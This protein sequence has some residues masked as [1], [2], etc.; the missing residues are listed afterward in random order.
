MLN[1]SRR[2]KKILERGPT[3]SRPLVFLLILTQAT[4]VAHANEKGLFLSIYGGTFSSSS[5]DFRAVYS[6][7]PA[8][9]IG[10]G[11]G[12]QTWGRVSTFVEFMH[13]AQYSRRWNEADRRMWTADLGFAYALLARDEH[14][15]EVSAGGMIGLS[16]EDI[17]DG[18]KFG[19]AGAFAGLSFLRRFEGTPLAV[20]LDGRYRYAP[21]L[22]SIFTTDY[23]G[24]TVKLG[25]RY[26]L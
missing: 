14:S 25:L 11:L 5:V 10:I 15:L 22:S 24:T 9:V 12:H 4:I 7:E 19:V 8:A 2:H 20:V 18:E 26:M 21:P 1:R 6:R 3:L 16:R 13:Y 17:P 23:S